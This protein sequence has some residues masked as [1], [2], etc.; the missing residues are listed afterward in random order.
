MNFHDRRRRF[1]AILAGDRC[2]SPASV[3]DPLSARAAA[4]LGFELAMLAGS[5]ASATVLGAPDLVVLTLTELAEQVRRIGR[6]SDMPLLVDADHGY[7]NALNVLRC[8]QELE[9]AGVAALTIEDTL[10]PRPF[11]ASGDALISSAE[12]AGKLRAAMDT[13]DDPELVILGRTS[14]VRLAGLDE[15]SRRVEAYSAAGVDGFFFVG[16]QTRQELEALRSVTPLPFALG[17]SSM[18][19]QD[20]T[21]LAGQG[22]R[23]LLQGHAPFQAAVKA[24]HDTLKA[25]RQGSARE[26]TPPALMADLTA[27]RAYDRDIARYLS[28]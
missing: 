27:Q 23:I 7:G 10:L 6:A 24:V 28:E 3:F 21:Y 26:S 9:V 13:R 25:L 20:R 11:A 17:S 15:C 22:V 16:L 18:E 1:R 14:A 12:A 19:L 5:V 8:V 4:S 2:V